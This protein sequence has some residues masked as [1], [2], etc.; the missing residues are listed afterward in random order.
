M[1]ESGPWPPCCWPEELGS[2]PAWPDSEHKLSYCYNVLRSSNELISA[3][4]SIIPLNLATTK[5]PNPQHIS[6]FVY[7][8]VIF[9]IYCT[10][11]LL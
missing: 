6:R 5:A 7:L 8:N 1:S 9:Y 10:Y 4:A 2:C 3:P 11:N